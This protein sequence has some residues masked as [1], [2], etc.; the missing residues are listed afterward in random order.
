MELVEEIAREFYRR[1]PSKNEIV[2]ITDKDEIRELKKRLETGKGY[3]LSGRKGR[4]K[5]N[6]GYWVVVPAC[7]FDELPQSVKQ[8]FFS[9]ANSYLAILNT[10]N[11]LFDYEIVDRY[12]DYQSLHC[13]SINAEHYFGE[14]SFDCKRILENYRW[15]RKMF[16]AR[17][18]AEEKEGMFEYIAQYLHNRTRALNGFGQRKLKPKYVEISDKLADDLRHRQKANLTYGNYHW[19]LDI[20]NCPFYDLPSFLRDF[21]LNL[22]Q[23]TYPLYSSPV[24]LP[25]DQVGEGFY[26]AYLKTNPDGKREAKPFQELTNREKNIHMAMY[27]YC[28]EA[29]EDYTCKIDGELIEQIAAA[30]YIKPASYEDGIYVTITDIDCLARLNRIGRDFPPNYRFNKAKGVYEFDAS[31]VEY[32]DLP[33]ENKRAERSRVR[34]VIEI[35]QDGLQHSEE[36]IG[37][38]L[39]QKQR[40][41][42]YYVYSYSRFPESFKEQSVIWSGMGQRILDDYHRIKELYENALKERG[43]I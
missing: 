33:E 9:E 16:L 29:Y 7:P 32:I 42:S 40:R 31:K 6:R 25:L 3:I 34:D 1:H 5:L 4:L 15:V 10:R 13:Y 24:S 43:N 2:E 8:R 37:E 12:F 17:Q 22:A 11:R 36:E 20:A 38:I 41:R 18:P 30:S 14:N 27:R 23:Q 19:L 39:L 35:L 21:F 26:R 28:L